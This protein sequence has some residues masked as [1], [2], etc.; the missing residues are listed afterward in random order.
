MVVALVIGSNAEGTGLFALDRCER[1]DLVCVPSPPGRDLGSTSFLAATRYCERRRALLVWDPPWAW[2]SADTAVMALRASAQTSRHALTYFPRVRPRSD[3]G[4]YG[5]GMP[6]CGVIAG[7]QYFTQ[8]AQEYRQAID[9][10][11]TIPS[12]GDSVRSLRA[13]QRALNAVEERIASLENDSRSS[14]GGDGRARPEAR[15]R[16]VAPSWAAAS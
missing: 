15:S 8:A 13:A 3:L 12:F 16:L 10:Y 4:R 11:S 6:A 2:T 1:V 7:L 5:S 14:S 9:F